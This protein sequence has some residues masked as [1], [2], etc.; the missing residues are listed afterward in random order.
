MLSGSGR[1]LL[2]PYVVDDEQI[3][4]EIF[5]EQASVGDGFFVHEFTDEV[6]DRNVVFGLFTFD[7]FVAYALG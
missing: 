1:K 7:R 5:S 4:L 2:E 3:G 6:E